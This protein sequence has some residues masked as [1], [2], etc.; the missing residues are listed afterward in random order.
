MSI[1]V[2]DAELK[3]NKKSCHVVLLSESRHGKLQAASELQSRQQ[4]ALTP[5]GCRP[6]L[7]RRTRR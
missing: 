7:R 5:F 4:R 2:H 3:S 6:R 1:A